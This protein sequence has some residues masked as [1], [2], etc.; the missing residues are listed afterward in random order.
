MDHHRSWVW[1]LRGESLVVVRTACLE[2][3]DPRQMA[4]PAV[5]VSN[6]RGFLQAGSFQQALA[7]AQVV[8]VAAAPAPTQQH[9]Q[10]QQTAAA[11]GALHLIQL[12]FLAGVGVGGGGCV[13]AHK[14]PKEALHLFPHL[15]MGPQAPNEPQIALH[16]HQTSKL[17]TKR[18]LRAR[19]TARADS[20]GSGVGLAPRPQ[21]LPMP[22]AALVL[23][24]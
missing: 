17:I 16:R 11:E 20:P 10:H 9:Q 13:S 1:E 21:A 3:G 4:L 12:E 8:V 14:E 2:L 19:G 15:Q 22:A 7:G 6:S 23:Y 18:Y 5:V 24:V